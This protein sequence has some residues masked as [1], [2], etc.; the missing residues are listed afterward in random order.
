MPRASDQVSGDRVSGCARNSDFITI[1]KII[2]QDHPFIRV[3]DPIP[4]RLAR[5]FSAGPFVPSI[6]MPARSQFRIV[7]RSITWSLDA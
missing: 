7:N 6:K 1:G 2:I 3:I 4:I 5:L